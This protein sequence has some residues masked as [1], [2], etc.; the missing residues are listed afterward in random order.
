MSLFKKI[1]KGLEEAI[2]FERGEGEARVIYACSPRDD[3]FAVIITPPQKEIELA[4][5][6][7]NDYLKRVTK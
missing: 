7:K 6:Y 1:K 2:A 5:K 3:R 4:L